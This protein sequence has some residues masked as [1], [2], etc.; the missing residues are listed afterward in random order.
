MEY[1]TYNLF[2]KPNAK[3]T[4]KSLLPGTGVD[5][6]TCGKHHASSSILKSKLD[7]LLVCYSLPFLSS[8]CSIPSAQLLLVEPL[9]LRADLPMRI[10]GK[11]G[12]EKLLQCLLWI[13]TVIVC[14]NQPVYLKVE[15]LVHLSF[16]CELC[17]SAKFEYLILTSSLWGEKKKTLH[18]Y[19]D[20]PF[21]G[22]IVWGEFCSLTFIQWCMSLDEWLQA[23]ASIMSEPSRVW[24]RRSEKAINRTVIFVIGLK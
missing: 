6:F 24:H 3:L 13:F 20:V 7:D 22:P 23:C 8:L 18:N 11:E 17:S 4:F 2:S 10:W 16:L 5:I 12:P 19:L 1:S 21:P 15:V 9:C 14:L